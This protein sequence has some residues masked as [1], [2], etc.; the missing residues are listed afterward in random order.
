MT[1]TEAGFDYAAAERLAEFQRL[2]AKL[3]SRE[4]AKV[5]ACMRGLGASEHRAGVAS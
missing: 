4:M 3:D 1:S 5:E 2:L